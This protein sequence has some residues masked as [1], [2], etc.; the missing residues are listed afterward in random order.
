MKHYSDPRT[1]EELCL[2]Y[3]DHA[4]TFKSDQGFSNTLKPIT[5]ARQKV[6]QVRVQ[7]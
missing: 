4:G 3:K 1:D 2:E 5:E 6:F 7:S